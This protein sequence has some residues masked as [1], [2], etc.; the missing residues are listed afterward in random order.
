MDSLIKRL[1]EPNT[2]ALTSKRGPHLLETLPLSIHLGQVINAIYVGRFGNN[3]HHTTAFSLSTEKGH[4]GLSFEGLYI[5][6]C[7]GDADGSGRG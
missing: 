4:S 6:Q 1:E 3:T 2:P 5:Q 7:W